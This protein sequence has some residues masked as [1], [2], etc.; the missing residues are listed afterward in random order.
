MNSEGCFILLRQELLHAVRCASTWLKA[1]LLFQAEYNA[2]HYVYQGI[3]HGK[4]KF[5]KQR[6]CWDKLRYNGTPSA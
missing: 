3:P 6:K 4:L 2:S 5:K 1:A